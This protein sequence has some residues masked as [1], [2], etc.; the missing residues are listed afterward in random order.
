MEI[1]AWIGFVSIFGGLLMILSAGFFR[2][3]QHPHRFIHPLFLGHFGWKKEWWTKPGYLLQRI[4]PILMATG[5]LCS[6]ISYLA[7][8]E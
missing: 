6:A 1:L 7:M 5:F 3:P 4:G 2:T 8:I